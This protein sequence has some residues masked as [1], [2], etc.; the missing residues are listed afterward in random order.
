MTIATGQLVGGRY[1]ILAPI[2]T[3]GMGAVYR[4]ADRH[5][6]NRT[7]A[8]KQMLE[9]SF[10]DDRELIHEKFE[11][12]AEMLLSLHHAGIPRV[13]DHFKM[14]DSHF[15]VMEFIHGDSLDK[16]LEQSLALA[17]Q[18]LASAHVV[19]IAIEVCEVL[20]Y[21]H[22]RQPPVIHRDIKP[23]NLIVRYSDNRV[24][25]V[26][27]GLARPL[28]TDSLQPKTLVGTLG[29]A[30]LEQVS[31]HPE[32]RSDI[33]GLGATMHHLMTG[34]MPAPFDI[35][36]L[37]TVLP[38][39]LP[40]L[41]RIVDTAT[42]QA[43]EMR[44]G[45]AAEM[46]DDLQAVLR[47]LDP[48]LDDTVEM[49]PPQPPEPSPYDTL[50]VNRNETSPGTVVFTVPPKPMAPQ[51]TVEELESRRKKRRVQ[52]AAWVAAA[53]VGSALLT[54]LVVSGP[55]PTEAAPNVASPS[56]G[57]TVVPQATAAI[58]PPGQ[59]SSGGWT[60][61][62]NH[63]KSSFNDGMMSLT[64]HPDW[65]EAVLRSP[66]FE[67][68]ANTDYEVRFGMP[69]SGTRT[70]H[71]SLVHGEQTVETPA[72]S[73]SD[74]ES[75]VDVHFGSIDA[76]PYQLVLRIAGEPGPVHLTDVFVYADNANHTQH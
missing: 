13:V 32:I 63:E 30:P 38:D 34:K 68:A 25:L 43:P 16:L 66:F 22:S 56:A 73:V 40:Q 47:L 9:D 19:N 53:A 57:A 72:T 4:A 42:Q 49:A 41:A 10:G 35:P 74:D 17:Q 71:C 26:D 44:Y 55:V 48:P 39:V 27:F 69:H 5:F 51:V 29:Y 59:L 70:V 14:G 33:Y 75:M 31:G 46:L 6:K 28:N 37:S 1:E 23:G 45:S 2:H 65:S 52:L 18:P 8:L 62:P 76:G 24:F 20:D 36:P 50:E 7:V 58:R 60:F 61:G 11:A 54:R 21:L 64:I 15:V 12:E 3:G 67:L